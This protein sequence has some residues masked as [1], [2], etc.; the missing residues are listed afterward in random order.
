M[1]VLRFA[2]E[3]LDPDLPLGH[4]VQDAD[5]QPLVFVEKPF[6]LDV[7]LVLVEDAVSSSATHAAA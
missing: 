3:W 7:L 1:P 5:I 6:D 4:A 2:E